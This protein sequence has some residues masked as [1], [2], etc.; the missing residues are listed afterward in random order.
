M[1]SRMSNEPLLQLELP[2]IKKLK[3]GKVREI[4]DLGDSLLTF[5]AGVSTS[6]GGAL[7]LKVEFL[8]TYKNKPAQLGIE[9]NDTA[10]VTALVVK[11]E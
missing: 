1:L 4:F 6:L 2:G 5:A 11:F 7:E 8:D 3:S 9:K 10:F